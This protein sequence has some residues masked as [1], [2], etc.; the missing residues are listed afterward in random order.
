MYEKNLKDELFACHMYVKIPFDVLQNMPIMERKYYIHKYNEYMEARN[1]AMNGD[2]SSS[3]S[4][5]ISRYTSMSQGLD[6]N[7]IAEEMGL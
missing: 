3:S 2:N 4:S 5:D 6:G 7:D 1:A